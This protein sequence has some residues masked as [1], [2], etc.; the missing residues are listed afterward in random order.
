MVEVCI[1]KPLGMVLEEV[2]A[3]DPSQG[4][5]IRQIN[6]GSNACQTDVCIN[7]QIIAVNGDESC[8]A[9]DAI[10]DRIAQET[11]DQVTLTLQ[12]PSNAVVV[13][14]PN[15]VKVAAPVGEYLGNIAQDAAYQDQIDFDCRSG[16]CGTC[17]HWAVVDNNTEKPRLY[18]PCSAKVP[19]GVETIQILSRDGVAP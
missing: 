5:C 18:R 8:C 11:S 4:V 14:W 9:F 19:K 3:N 2:D 12:R 7:D 1:P 17:A 10:M 6:K 16:S 13:C 15:G